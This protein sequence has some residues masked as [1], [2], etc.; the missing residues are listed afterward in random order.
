M[1][2][3]VHFL[4][5]FSWHYTNSDDMA[6]ILGGGQKKITNNSYK[7]LQVKSLTTFLHV[8][9]SS[10]CGVEKW[11]KEFKKFILLKKE[12]VS[13]CMKDITPYQLSLK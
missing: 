7:I 9:R 6:R 13:F 10:T 12:L 8:I 5:R 4:K 1:E 3:Y 2:I 11:E